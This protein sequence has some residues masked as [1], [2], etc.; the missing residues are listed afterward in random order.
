MDVRVCR[1]YARDATI[2]TRNSGDRASVANAR[3]C[4]AQTRPA[5][6]PLIPSS[7]FCQFSQPFQSARLADLPGAPLTDTSCLGLWWQLARSSGRFGQISS[8]ACVGIK[9]CN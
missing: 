3:I 9:N 5:I 6:R 2:F 1:T 4:A 8:I 7:G